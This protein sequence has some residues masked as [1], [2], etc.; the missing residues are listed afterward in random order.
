MDKWEQG[1]EFDRWAKDYDE[2]IRKEQRESG[3]M[4]KDYDKILDT[5][6]ELAEAKKDDF[7][8]DIG[9][10]TGAL[11][12]RFLRVTKNVYGVDPSSEMLRIAKRKFPKATV[13]KG[14]F[15]LIPFKDM[16]FDVIV[17]SY[18][19]HHLS[20]KRKELALKK[21]MSL[22]K[23]GGRIIIADI[24]FKNPSSKRSIVQKLKKSGRNDI[25]EE[26]EDEHFGL[27]DHLKSVLK[28]DFKV[29]CKQMTDF[30]WIVVVKKR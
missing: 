22:L 12:E 11:L 19:L 25:V 16:T 26:L 5:V 7:V 29:T 24:M 23:E 20:D 28:E 3:W 14:H 4:Y 10:G 27:C 21:L 9:T 6:F 15:L 8:L 1:K 30:V 17:S 2:I 13:K 18:A